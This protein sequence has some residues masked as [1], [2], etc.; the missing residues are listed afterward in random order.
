MKI[1]ILAENFYPE[2][3]APAKRL[4]DHAKVDTSCIFQEIYK[5]DLL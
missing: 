5:V 2:T 4:F 3:N 1:L